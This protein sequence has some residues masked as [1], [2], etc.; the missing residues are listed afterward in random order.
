MNTIFIFLYVFSILFARSGAHNEICSK[1]DTDL[2]RE[3]E[4]DCARGGGKKFKKRKGGRSRRGYI[5]I[6]LIVPVTSRGIQASNTIAIENLPIYSYLI[7]SMS[8]L[9]TNE[10]NFAITTMYLGYDEGDEIYDNRKTVK[11]LVKHFKNK[12]PFVSVKPIRLVGLSQRIAHIWNHLVSI[13]Y[14]DGNEYFC[15]LSDDSLLL[16]K[17]WLHSLIQALKRNPFMSNFGTVAFFEQHKRLKPGTFPTFPVIHKTHLDIF[18]S[19]EMIHPH[20]ANSFADPYISDLYV[21]FESSRIVEVAKIVNVIGGEDTPRYN[22]GFPGWDNYVD[23]VQMGRRKIAKWLNKNK[24][25]SYTWTLAK[26]AYGPEGIH[27]TDYCKV[28]PGC[29]MPTFNST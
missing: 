20:F 29:E 19:Q 21:V 16:S 5:K 22:P 2:N 25:G 18:G 28:S 4:R 23:L 8:K 9:Q 11:A 14:E 12:V 1:L 17:G 7:S 3:K 26:L 15:V 24:E 6:A 10:T 13:A 27:Y